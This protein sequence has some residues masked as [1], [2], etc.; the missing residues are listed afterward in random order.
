MADIRT[1]DPSPNPSQNS[2]PG[3]CPAI[4]FTTPRRRDRAVEEPQWINDFL[5]RAAI[6]V[7]ATR[8]PHG[9]S[10]NPNLFVYDAPNRV[11]YLHTAKKGHTR[12]QLEQQPRVAFSVSEMGRLLPSDAAVN[13]SV[14]YASVIAE[15]TARIIDDADDAERALKLFM[16]KY[17]PQFEYGTDYRGVSGQDLARTTVIEVRIESWSAKRKSSDAEDAYPYSPPVL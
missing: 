3:T 4:S 1:S 5:S 8:G 9:P 11:L 17:A 2:T 10:L 16:E 7:L 15:G 6:G 14:E 12:T 13:F